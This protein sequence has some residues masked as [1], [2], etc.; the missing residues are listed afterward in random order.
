M[1]QA[2]WVLTSAFAFIA[3]LNVILLGIGSCMGGA[4]PSLDEVKLAKI[5]NMVLG[6]RHCMLA[7]LYASV[8]LAFFN[9]DLATV[10]ILLSAFGIGTGD[11]A[12]FI[13]SRM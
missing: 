1:T 8:V 4:K 12:I 9:S 7:L 13:L 11:V 5:A 3:I 2:I 10:G 6:L